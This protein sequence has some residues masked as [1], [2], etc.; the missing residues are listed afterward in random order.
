M[1]SSSSLTELIREE[2][3]EEFDLTGTQAASSYVPPS[4][5]R[6][7]EER[8][9]RASTPTVPIVVPPGKTSMQFLAILK[10]ASTLNIFN[11][12][13]SQP[14]TPRMEVTRLPED[15]K[16]QEKL[17]GVEDGDAFKMEKNNNDSEATTLKATLTSETGTTFAPGMDSSHTNGSDPVRSPLSF[18]APPKAVVVPSPSPCPPSPV[19]ALQLVPAAPLPSP[20]AEAILQMQTRRRAQAT[21]T[22][23]PGET[24]APPPAQ[25]GKVVVPRGMFKSS[26]LSPV[27]DEGAKKRQK[28][29]RRTLRTST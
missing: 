28:E 25:G 26:P 17:K 13:K 24:V 10:V 22:S 7:E 11:R 29:R 15:I 3:L 19:P 4:A 2:I 6:A 21:M 14:G 1:L 8:S 9:H 20:L 12:S 16:E 5:R 23:G 18:S 27:A